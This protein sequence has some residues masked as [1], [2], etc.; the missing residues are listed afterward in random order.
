[1]GISPQEMENQTFIKLVHRGMEN[2]FIK[3]EKLITINAVGDTIIVNNC[4]NTDVLL[5]GGSE[6]EDFNKLQA[7]IDDIFIHTPHINNSVV[8]QHFK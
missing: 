1:M 6:K 4:F 8:T 5:P 3:E 2:N 7:Y